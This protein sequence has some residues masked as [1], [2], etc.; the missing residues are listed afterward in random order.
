MLGHCQIL[1]QYMDELTNSLHNAEELFIIGKRIRKGVLIYSEDHFI[2]VSRDGVG[3]W[4]DSYE[5]AILRFKDWGFRDHGGFALVFDVVASEDSVPYSSPYQ[6]QYSG[7]LAEIRWPGYKNAKA[8]KIVPVGDL[9]LY[10]TYLH[11]TALFEGLVK[12]K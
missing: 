7:R 4:V 10:I 12:K 2:R 9:P 8:I 11:K 1:R 6:Q 3:S 5:P